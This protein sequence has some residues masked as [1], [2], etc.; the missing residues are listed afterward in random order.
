MFAFNWTYVVKTIIRCDN[1]KSNTYRLTRV[2]IIGRD[3]RKVV[4]CLTHSKQNN[5]AQDE[6]YFFRY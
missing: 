5:Y 3:T 6:H 1:S 2:V 4:C